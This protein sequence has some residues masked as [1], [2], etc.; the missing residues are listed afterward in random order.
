MF[1]VSA[2]TKSSR[3]GT[4]T[5]IGSRYSNNPPNLTDFGF[6]GNTKDGNF[7]A[8][9]S[10]TAAGAIRSATVWYYDANNV[11]S[12]FGCGGTSAVTCSESHYIK[13]QVASR[14]RFW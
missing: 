11:I 8:D 7:E 4:Y 14:T 6:T 1:T 9:V 3:N 10:I 12:F 13:R 5:V 2:A